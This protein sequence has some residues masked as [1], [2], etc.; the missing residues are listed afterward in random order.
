MAP[1]N[2]YSLSDPDGCASAL[3]TIGRRITTAIEKAC[4]AAGLHSRQYELLL[5]VCNWPHPNP[6]SMKDIARSLGVRHNSAVE[7]TD[8]AEQR[9]TVQRIAGSADRRQVFVA[10]TDNGRRALRVVA[11][12]SARDLAAILPELHNATETFATHQNLGDSDHR[13][14]ADKYSVAA[15]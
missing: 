10:I 4:A 12:T 9:G 14:H 11:E 6:P 15:V 2:S 13:E 1:N 7:L 5:T 8:R 3:Y